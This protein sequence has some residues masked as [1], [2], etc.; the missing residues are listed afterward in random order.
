LIL[1]ALAVAISTSVGVLCERRSGGAQAAARR[2]LRLMLYGLVP[3]VS[4][5]NIAHLHVTLGA[6]VGLGLAYIGIAAVGVAAWA[7]GRFWLR[8]GSPAIGALICCV[9]VVNTGYLGFPMTVALLGAKALGSAVAYDQLVGG[10]ML[11]LVGFGVGAAFGD[12]AGAGGRMR[13]K[14]FLTRNPPLLAVIAGLLAPA[15]LA[16]APLVRA[17]HVVVA[18][19]LVLGFF[20]VGIILS[21]ERRQD[22]APLF[23]WPDRRVA[24]ALGLRLL[25]VPLFLAVISAVVIRL[26]PA[27]LLEAA[28]PAGISSLIVGQAYGLDQHLIAMIIVWT[29]AIALAAG[30]VIAAL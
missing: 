24:V 8:L 1:V 4:F 29:T 5:V 18:A 6:G 19:M 17:S 23:A 14:A 16:P 25:A 13:V 9:I 21:A 11:F 15:A 20:A 10:P 22:A 28:M 30:L 3:F 12:R 7:I 2:T 27:Y 26:P